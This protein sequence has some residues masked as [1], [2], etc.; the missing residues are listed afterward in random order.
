MLRAHLALYEYFPVSIPPAP[1]SL[2]YG[3]YVN[4]SGA[5][6]H[7]L[8]HTRKTRVER[9]HTHIINHGTSS[10]QTHSTVYNT[11][12]SQLRTAATRASQ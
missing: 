5:Q 9:V 12:A 1:R 7:I 11:R 3:A 2:V 8:I 10:G 6:A 4:G